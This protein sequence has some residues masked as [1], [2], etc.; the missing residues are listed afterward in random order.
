[1]AANIDLID[2]NTLTPKEIVEERE[3]ALVEKRAYNAARL[4][5]EEEKVKREV[6][7]RRL[8]ALEDNRYFSLLPDRRYVATYWL[9]ERSM[10]MRL[11]GLRYKYKIPEISDPEITLQLWRRDVS[12]DEDMLVGTVGD[13]YTVWLKIPADGNEEEKI[14]LL[15]E[16]D[17]SRRSTQSRMFYSI[18][19]CGHAEKAFSIPAEAWQTYMLLRSDED[20]DREELD[21]RLWFVA[22]GDKG[23]VGEDCTLENFRKL[24][25]IQLKNIMTK[26][27][28]GLTYERPTSQ[29]ALLAMNTG[30]H[31]VCE[32]LRTEEE[33]DESKDKVKLNLEGKFNAMDIGQSARVLRSKCRQPS[34]NLQASLEEMPALEESLEAEMGQFEDAEDDDEEEKSE[35]EI[36]YGVKKDVR[37]GIKN[38]LAACVNPPDEEIRA[39]RDVWDQVMRAEKLFPRYKSENRKQN[40]DDENST[41]TSPGAELSYM[42]DMSQMTDDSRK[43]S[44]EYFLFYVDDLVEVSEV[45]KGMG[46]KE[47]ESE[48]T[49]ER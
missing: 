46:E 9:S 26:L 10:K 42:G 39:S 2:C 20:V 4:K 27:A 6:E 34:I 29:E 44:G 43:T 24:D 17:E 38:I 30:T 22:I 11:E 35:D 14:N 40:E 7:E 25:L 33:D 3:R 1:M 21:T 5:A 18:F 23:S 32:L 37:E 15:V 45:D 13:L 47:K 12:T 8:L 16:S 28:P 31:Y 19:D 41:T 48:V 36:F 49:Q